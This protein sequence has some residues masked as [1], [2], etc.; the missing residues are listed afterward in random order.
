MV[1]KTT[2][3]NK[4]TKIAKLVS[5]RRPYNQFVRNYSKIKNVF[6]KKGFESQDIDMFL[7]QSLNK[8][9]LTYLDY[10]GLLPANNY[11]S[12]QF[13]FENRTIKN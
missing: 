1:K 3:A 4:V 6:L 12:M 10:T 8:C 2:K 5:V 7:L 13:A 11:N 9:L